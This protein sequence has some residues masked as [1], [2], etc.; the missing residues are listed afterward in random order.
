MEKMILKQLAELHFGHQNID[1]IPRPLETVYMDWS[2][3]PFGAGYHAW[4][5]HFNIAEVMNNIRTPAGR[6]KHIYII[7]S[8]YSNDQAWIEGAFCTAESVLTE[9]LGLKPLIDTA[10]YPLIC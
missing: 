5:T 2:L 9:F 1:S 7:G 10:N 6:N 8:A 4:E 3:D